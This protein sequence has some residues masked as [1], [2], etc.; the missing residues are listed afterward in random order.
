MRLNL[1]LLLLPTNS[2]F[3]EIQRQAILVVGYNFLPYVDAPFVSI[4]GSVL[5]C[6]RKVHRK[7]TFAPFLLSATTQQR[8]TL[9][10]L[11]YLQ[12]WQ[13]SEQHC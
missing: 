13:V 5:V 9:L 2:S 7:L 3:W 10:N 11:R 12:L 4:A 8:I 6:A 1:R